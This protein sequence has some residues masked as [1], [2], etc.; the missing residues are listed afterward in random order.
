M[1]LLLPFLLL[2]TS[3]ARLI[4]LDLAL[5]PAGTELPPEPPGVVESLEV[6]VA[7]RTLIVRAAVRRTDVVTSAGEVEAREQRLPPVADG[8]DLG[9]LQGT[10]RQLK[11]I[12]PKRARLVL[13]PDD[14]L[15]TRQLVLL[16]DAVRRD[17]QG[18]LYP[19]V[20]LGAA[21]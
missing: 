8:L 13:A 10:L 18:E 21:P 17:R 15:P 4:G 3:V 1:F 12:D 16:M 9:G 5:P 20:A 7:Q 19:D 2:T 6:E 11:D 14:A